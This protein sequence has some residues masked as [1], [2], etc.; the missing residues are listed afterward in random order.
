V[1]DA[2]VRAAA[3]A[4][5]REKVRMYGDLLPRAELERGFEYDGRRVPLVGP[6][7]IFK[8]AV[9][10]DMPLSITTVPVVEG[11]QRPYE[12]EVRN[13]GLLEYRYR[14]TDIRHPDNL[15]LRRA[16]ERQA[17]L[18]Y[19]HGIAPGWYAA[20]FP[21]Y[22][23]NDDPG[24]LTF[25]I[26]ADEPAMAQRGGA[27]D[28]ARRRYVTR[29]MQ[30]RIHQAKFRARVLL[31]YSVRCTI[32]RLHDHPELLDAAHILPD[33]HPRGA[34]IVP[35]GLALCKLH[36]AAFDANL[37]GVRPDHVV[38]VK[39]RLLEEIDGPMLVHGLQGFDG[40]TITVPRRVELRPNREFLEERYE[41]FRAAS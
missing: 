36:H 16:F 6:P 8:P 29:V 3:F 38:E 34:P 11:R 28:S 14:G 32:C 9:L 35:N 17:P 31:A 12:D 7:G 33:G 41:L 25:T 15:G 2:S 19:F 1:W 27:A 21:V 4:F 18:V 23:V 13:D 20:V 26:Q 24:R 10:L 22:V 40:H 37:V 39:R 30:Q 5:L